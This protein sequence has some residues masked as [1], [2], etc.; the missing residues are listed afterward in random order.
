M[1][2]QG[3]VWV[4]VLTSLGPYVFKASNLNRMFPL[5]STQ[6]VLAFTGN[7]TPKSNTESWIIF[8]HGSGKGKEIVKDFYDIMSREFVK[9]KNPIKLADVPNSEYWHKDITSCNIK[10]PGD[11]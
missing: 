10:T 8:T 2:S 9:H 11:F 7:I 4:Q 3:A 1:N 6:I 5:S